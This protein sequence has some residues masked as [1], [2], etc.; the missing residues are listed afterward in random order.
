MNYRKF[1]AELTLVLCLA[2]GSASLKAER[3]AWLN[4]ESDIKGMTWVDPTDAKQGSAKVSISAAQP[5]K[6]KGCVEASFSWIAPYYGGAFGYNWAGWDKS[7]ALDIRQAKSLEFWIR[8][9]NGTNDHFVF[10]LTDAAGKA[11]DKVDAGNYLP[12]K[13]VTTAWQKVSVPAKD[14]KGSFD[15]TQVWEFDADTHANPWGSSGGAVFYL[16]DA[17]FVLP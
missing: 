11:G 1:R 4:G 13:L 9:E 14:L 3:K 15:R 6:G 8:V 7:K 12:G 17:A 10:W 16:D 5:H 2:F